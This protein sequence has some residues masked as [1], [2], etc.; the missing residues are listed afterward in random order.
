MSGFD[1]IQLA[2]EFAKTR[3]DEYQTQCVRFLRD[4]C[5]RFSKFLGVACCGKD[6][7]IGVNGIEPS[8]E[9][10][11]YVDPPFFNS[12]DASVWTTITIR[13]TRRRQVD[14]AV[15]HSGD[16]YLIRTLGKDFGGDECEQAILLIKDA[17]VQGEDD[18][19]GKIDIVR[20]K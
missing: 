12:N 20:H 14:V 15:W 13:A 10:V 7:R 6:R 18:L 9:K 5:D 3:K 16:S 19:D 1:Q 11:S 17:I 2:Q 4:L 8:K